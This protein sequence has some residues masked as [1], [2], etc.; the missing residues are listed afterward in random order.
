MT[1]S[2]ARKGGQKKRQAPR[3]SK[4]QSA[5]VRAAVSSAVPS[6]PSLAWSS[7]VWVRFFFT[8][9]RGDYG[10]LPTVGNAQRVM[11]TCREELSNIPCPTPIPMEHTEKASPRLLSSPRV[12]MVDPERALYSTGMLTPRIVSCVAIHLHAT[13]RF[14]VEM[15]HFAPNET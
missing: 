14:F 4:K 3:T 7:T 5:L 9:T 15:L 11:V 6:R 2:A 1:F 8:D 13:K 10:L 12:D